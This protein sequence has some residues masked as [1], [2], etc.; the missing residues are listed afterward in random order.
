M[1]FSI[2]KEILQEMLNCII[3]IVE[4]KQT[5]PILNNA[6]L[7]IKNGIL[8][9]IG[10]D[11]ENYVVTKRD[12]DH[13]IDG[14]ITFPVRKVFDICRTLPE[15]SILELKQENNFL[16]IASK[17]SRFSL[18][19]LSVKEFPELEEITDEISVLILA[20]D[21]KNIL[22]RTCYVIADQEVRFFLNGLFLD[23]NESGLN[24]VAMDGHRLSYGSV[25]LENIDN[26]KASSLVPKKSVFEILR[27]ISNLKGKIK[28]GFS[29]NF[30]KVETE[31]FLFVTKL[32]D[33]KFPD[34]SRIIPKKGE[35]VVTVDKDELKKVL[36]RISILANKQNNSAIFEF[37]ENLIS[38][39]A[40]NNEQEKA[41]EE[42]Q[43]QY[44]GSPITV[45]FNLKY[46]LEFLNIIGPQK[47]NI[48]FSDPKEGFLIEEEQDN[49][50]IYMVMPIY[51]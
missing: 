42:I 13:Q 30:F 34:Y 3:N 7:R 1:N 4:K 45:S 27:L 22:E 16:K 25:N 29:N 40:N 17:N 2:K 32:L 33:A 48:I 19:I 38:V 36:I 10:T 31:N 39:I 11:L 28:L 41:E 5:L 49:E 15:N 20:E 21:F 26:K 18:S 44:N 43:A 24:V 35:Y 14:D 12:I 37:K 50:F 51:L 46:I 47:I 8:E 6:R 23:L 9:I